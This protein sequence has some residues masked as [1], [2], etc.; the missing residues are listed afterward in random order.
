LAYLLTLHYAD[1]AERV[2]SV[3]D[4]QTVLEAAEASGVPI[5][6]ACQ[7]G[8]CG[9]CVALCTAGTYALGTSI[10]LSEAEKSGGRI[11]TCQTRIS[12]DC[13]VE[14]DYPLGRNAASMVSG[15]ATVRTVT[16]LS[17]T[18]ALLTLDTSGLP[19]PL[20][21]RPG[22][23]AQI[24]VPGTDLWRSYSFA[25]APRE[26]P[27][28]EFLI[29][30][31]PHGVMSAYLRE[32]CRAGDRIA[33]RG[34][35]GDFYLRDVTRPT[36]LLAGGTGL[37]AIL[38]IADQL[39]RERC[40][41][42][43]RLYYGVNRSEELVLLERLQDLQ[44][45]HAQ[46][47]W[48]TIVREPTADWHGAVGCVTDLLETSDLD[49]SEADVYLCGPP[50]MVEAA[51]EWMQHRGLHGASVYF[52]KFVAT[53]SATL[54]AAAAVPRP[55]RDLASIRRRGRGTA[56]VI[57]GSIAGIAAAK[58]LTEFFDKVVVLEKDL[59]HRR[60]EGRPGAAQGWHLHHLLLAGQRLLESIFPGIIGE[61]VDAG[62]FKVDM[63]EQYRV[64]IAGSW[65]KVGR[66][67][68][69]IVCAGRP[70]LE[71]CLRRR[72]DSEESVD[73]RY[74]SE[75][76]DLVYCPS[77]EAVIGVE[78]ERRGARE[79]VAAEFV[80]DAAGKN[81]P[82]PAALERAGLEPPE[83][84]EDQINCFYST[85]RHAVG[86]QRAWRDKVMT[87]CY[88]HRPQQQ[89]Y[90]AQYFTDRSRRVLSTT[91]VGYNCYGP[92]RNAEEFREFARRM[93]SPL[94]GDELDGLE[95]CSPVYNF[96]YPTM[97]RNRYELLRRPPAGLVAVGDAYASA[98]PVS[99]A[100]MSKAMM[101]LDELRA[102]LRQRRIRDTA[103]VRAYY[104]RIR[105]T[106]DVVWSVI[107]E[108][109]LRFP[110]IPDVKRKRPF[111]FRLQNWYVDRVF[112]GLHEDPEIYRRYL[113][114]SH[115]V[116]PPRSLLTPGIVVKVLGRWLAVRL[117]GGAT[118][119]ERN[120][121][122]GAP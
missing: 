108:Q 76:K 15:E 61:M 90:A 113:A 116:A 21:F 38:A 28:V 112:E 105:R 117:Q 94:I 25:H 98:D 26:E 43:I 37:S 74:E 13:T 81:T 99:G 23:F 11:L 24:K 96:R 97:Q 19:T 39:V 6:S 58:V 46:F 22:Q 120:F 62:A 89:H 107:R 115:F 114:V 79:I 40:A 75:A 20:H 95:P 45:A 34:S 49:H 9:T 3:E 10:G 52:E 122:R 102:L 91:L 85:M 1:G 8:V 17:P 66:S 56:V 87:I 92:P 111:H 44:T 101:E 118:L 7:A 100:G 18:S 41:R 51:R 64:M 71:W 77:A 12:S 93:P 80:V 4:G 103:F 82:V 42:P 16:L 30:L 104:G 70:L 33:I 63:G 32:R 121:G 53:G 60:M 48:Q 78:V 84:E 2:V 110:W 68:I 72:L 67:G 50:A 27:T 106:A 29:R 109:N 119:I 54:H 57:G 35:K 88:A 83:A 47:N 5:V 36:I 31:L 73:F 65:K 14:L 55:V 86:E 69:E 59:D